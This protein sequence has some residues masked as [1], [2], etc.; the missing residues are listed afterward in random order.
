VTS[1]SGAGLNWV[2][3]KRANGQAGTAEIWRAFSP[4]IQINET[5]TATLASAATG[6]LTVMALSGV[7]ATGTDGSGA[8]GASAA[9]SAATGAPSVSLTTT[10]NASGVIGVG[11]DTQTATARTIPAGQSLVHSFLPAGATYWT[12]AYSATIATAGTLTTVNDTAPTADRYNIAA[13]EILPANAN[14]VTINYP[15][16]TI[17]DDVM[18]ASIGFRPSSA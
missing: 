2:L 6:S 10:R 8:I 12:Q 4:L 7:D 18:I 1:V 16:G 3:V 15:P 14:N 9:N 5:V 17:Q 11:S 13:V